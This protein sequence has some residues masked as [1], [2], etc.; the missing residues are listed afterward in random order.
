MPPVGNANFASVQH[1]IHH[2]APRGQAGF[3]LA[4]GSMSSNQSGE[5]GIRR[6]IVEADLVAC[7]VA[8][9]GQLF[10]TAQIPVCLWFLDKAKPEARRGQTLFLDA[11]KLAVIELK[12]PADPQATD[13]SAYAQLQTYKAD[14]PLL[15]AYNEALVISDGLTA[16][17]G[18]LT[19]AREWFLPWRTIEGER[20]AERTLPEL[21]VLI[22]GALA[23]H[24]F[25]DLIRY[26][27]GF[28]DVG[29]GRLAKKM[30]AYHQ[31]R[32]VNVAMEQTLR[33]SRAS[34]GRGRKARPLPHRAAGRRG[35]G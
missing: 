30:A 14:I 33:A 1:F 24:R 6:A 3:V 9:P 2:L 13:W 11:R 16:G 7:M 4:N 26:F 8:L 34:R 31:F 12:N 15:L 23:P 35:G 10:Y 22:Q 19:A 29:G 20:E 25:L 21:Q 17:L 28:E 18:T 5:G 27:I 32:A